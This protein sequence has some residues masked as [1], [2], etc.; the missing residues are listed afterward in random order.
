MVQPLLVWR[1]LLAYCSTV[2][3]STLSHV[4]QGQNSAIETDDLLV[5][6]SDAKSDNV[7]GVNAV[8]F[9]YSQLYI[10]IYIN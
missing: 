10:Y 1:L 7:T 9:L 3:S 6:D 8:H 2:F 5:S 4:F